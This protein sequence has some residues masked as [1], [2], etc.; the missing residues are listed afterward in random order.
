M[1]V[2]ARGRWFIRS[3]VQ[4]SVMETATVVYCSVYLVGNP[5]SVYELGA[6]VEKGAAALL[7]QAAVVLVTSENSG[8][9]FAVADVFAEDGSEGKLAE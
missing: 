2:V 7:L 6:W 1:C 9:V 3:E 5:Y 8:I 4:V